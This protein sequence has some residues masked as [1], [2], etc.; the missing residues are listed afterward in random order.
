M[1]HF[2]QNTPAKAIV[3]QKVRLLKNLRPIMLLRLIKTRAKGLM[4]NLK[5]MLNL[6][7]VVFG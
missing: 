6:K 3:N 1:Y 5:E 7:V 4:L 2:E